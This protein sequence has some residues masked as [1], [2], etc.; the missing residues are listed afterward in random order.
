MN[1]GRLQCIISV[2]GR[3]GLTF[4]SENLCIRKEIDVDG[5]AV[6]FLKR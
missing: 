1:E 2:L 6:E 5:K 3:Y 4:I